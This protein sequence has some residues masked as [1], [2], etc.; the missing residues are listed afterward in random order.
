MDELLAAKHRLN[1]LA[2]VAAELR[3]DVEEG[4]EAARTINA[5]VRLTQANL[6]SVDTQMSACRAQIKSLEAAQAKLAKEAAVE[7]KVE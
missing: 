3:R 2:T 7:A 4:I 5:K 6:R 1:E